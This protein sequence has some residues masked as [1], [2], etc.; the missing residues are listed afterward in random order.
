MPERPYSR[1]GLLGYIADA[2]ERCRRAIGEL[3]EARAA[4]RVTRRRGTLSYLELLL[5][6][7]RHV[8]HH[9]AQ[10]NLLLRQK[11]DEAPAWVAQAE[12]PPA[13][14]SQGGLSL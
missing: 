14:P 11:L 1:D 6:T 4:E 10:L 7:M 2:R 13:R 5:Y 12:L 9:A 3:T 8:Q